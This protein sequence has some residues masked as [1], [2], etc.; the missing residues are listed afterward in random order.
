MKLVTLLIV[1]AAF[2]F[3]YA[4]Y[5]EN[6]KQVNVDHTTFLKDLSANNHRINHSK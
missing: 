3:A 4:G 1:I 5:T 2:Y 6:T